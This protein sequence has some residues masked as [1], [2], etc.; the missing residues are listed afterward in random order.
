MDR[1]DASRRPATL[2]EE[3]DEIR[4]F[5]YANDDLDAGRECRRYLEQILFRNTPHTRAVT[6]ADVIL[7]SSCW[8]APQHD[9]EHQ[10]T[11]TA[12]T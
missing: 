6:P 10:A 1:I 3:L 2:I 7:Q 12:S 11:C 4:T 5:L 9:A 8:R